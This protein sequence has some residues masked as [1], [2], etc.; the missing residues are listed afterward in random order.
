MLKGLGGGRVGGGVI[1]T[2]TDLWPPQKKMDPSEN[3]SK[4]KRFQHHMFIMVGQLPKW[5][6]L[7]REK[8]RIKKAR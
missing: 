8:I 2:K 3:I 6:I 7:R 5:I 1:S 4:I